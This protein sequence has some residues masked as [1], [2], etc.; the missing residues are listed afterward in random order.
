MDLSAGNAVSIK[1]TGPGLAR[2]TP[3]ILDH[4]VELEFSPADGGHLLT[5]A[6]GVIEL[7][8]SGSPRDVVE[9]FVG[10]SIAAFDGFGAQVDYD[11]DTLKTG[12][13]ANFPGTRGVQS[14]VMAAGDVREGAPLYDPLENTTGINAIAR[15]I[16]PCAIDGAPTRIPLAF[17]LQ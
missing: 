12:F 3:D 5:R 11:A 16:A 9:A 10:D 2:Y 1:G 8:R 4:C 6:Y 15:E 13:L 17:V 14:Y 7:E